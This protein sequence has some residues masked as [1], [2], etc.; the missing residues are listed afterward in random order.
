MAP[1]QVDDLTI[2]LTPGIW[3]LLIN[4]LVG[5]IYL[6]PLFFKE[7]LGEIFIRDGTD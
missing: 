5:S 7:G 6:V 2:F 3:F 4:S 1:P